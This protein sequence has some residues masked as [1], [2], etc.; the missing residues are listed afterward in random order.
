MFGLAKIDEEASLREVGGEGRCHGDHEAR[1]KKDVKTKK[2]LAELDLWKLNRLGRAKEK[3][4]LF[5][6][7]K[8]ESHNSNEKLLFFFWMGKKIKKM[9]NCVFLFCK[10][11]NSTKVTR[12]LGRV[13][14]VFPV[15]CRVWCCIVS[16]IGFVTIRLEADTNRLSRTGIGRFFE[17][18]SASDFLVLT[19]SWASLVI[20]VAGISSSKLPK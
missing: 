4:V 18:C 19:S 12:H 1:P 3:F 5:C 14:Q 2:S 10:L 9:R 17:P 13:T 16:Y 20:S 7:S 6:S 15:Y 11:T 8:K